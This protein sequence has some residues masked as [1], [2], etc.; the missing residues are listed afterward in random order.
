MS[1]SPAASRAPSLRWARLRLIALF[2]LLYAAGQFQRVS[3]GVLAPILAAELGLA[4]DALGLVSGALF[5]ASASAQIPLG[6]LLDRYGARRTVPALLAIGVAGTLGYAAAHGAAAL[7]A[8]RMAIGFGYAAVMMGGFVVLARWFPRE[9]F[10]AA[11]GLMVA[12]GSVGGLA[13]TAPLALLIEAFGWRA[14]FVGVAVFSAALGALALAVVR[15]APPGY[16]EWGRRP[17]SLRESVRGLA[18]VL[19]EPGMARI[20]AM[21]LVSYG[22]AMAILGLWGG[23][24]FGDV[25]G[26][27]GPAIGRAL[28]A[29]ALATPLG[30][31]LAGPLDRLIRSRKRVVLGMAGLEVAAFAALAAF[32][33]ADLWLSCAL[34]FLALAGQTFYLP[35]A[36]HCRALFPDHLVGRANTMLNLTGIVGVAGMQVVTGFIV[37]AFPA[38]DGVA[39]PTAYRLVFAALAALILAGALAYARVEEAR[40]H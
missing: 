36:A 40:P 22:P 39:E 14:V 34:L 20:L 26:L 38:A 7:V 5:V 21:G 16:A 33:E 37:R 1:A 17:A 23:P 6:V 9:R 12:A 27:D 28:F 2:A 30:L 32:A 13:A 25:F 11:S 10:A 31:A 8:A 29:L 35:L 15:D 18:D 3:G 24:Y 19:R 4:A